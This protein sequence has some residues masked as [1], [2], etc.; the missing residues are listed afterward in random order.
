MLTIGLTGGIA[1][2][3]SHVAARFIT[4]GVPL[5]EADDVA[6]E[7]VE[8]G[9]PALAEIAARFG[10]GV[11]QADGSLNRRALRE[12]V[13]AD[14]EAR[15]ALEAITHQRIRARVAEWRAAQTAPY[16]IYSAAIL[17]EAGM[18]KLVDRV[19]VIDAP[20]EVQLQR[21]LARDG[22][23]ETLA[24]QMLAAQATRGQRLAVA[25]D[26]I[27]N[28]DVTRDIGP[29]LGRLDAFYRGIARQL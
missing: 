1:S 18:T 19:L 22:G 24:R 13:F 3:K 16:G 28:S 26:V 6:R 15:R 17:I 25:H 9:R 12:Q 2:G 20:Q 4:M 10:A 8:P 7:V 5:L 27:D 23:S 21:L 11:I 29:Q 14:P